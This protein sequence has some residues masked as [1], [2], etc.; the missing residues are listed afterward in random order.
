[1]GA[2]SSSEQTTVPIEQ[3]EAETLAASTGALST[4][5]KCFSNLAD[6]HSGAIPYDSLQ[7]CFRL[8]YE[9]PVCE[10]L[11]IPVSF[12]GVLDHVGC[13]IAE[14]FFVTEK[15]GVSW[16][17]FVRGYNR[18][19]ARKTL[20]MSVTSLLRVFSVALKKAGLPCNLEF[21]TGDDD[22]KISGWLMPVDVL[23]LLW[24]CWA[25]S[26][27][28]RTREFPREKGK[29]CL[30]DV[31]HIVLSA[32]ESCAEAESGLNVWDCELSGL[33]VQLPVG[34]FLTW[35]LKTVSTLPGCFAEFVYAVLKHSASQE[36]GLECSTSSAAVT[37]STMA[38]SSNLLTPGIAWAV[39]L[40][41]TGPLSEE[42]SR[43][44]FPSDANGI[45]NDLLYRSHL[46]GRGLNR[47]WSNVQGYQGPLLVLISATSEDGSA[48]KRNWIV[49]VLTHQGFE[50][51]D[52]FYG[53]SGSLYA[54]S[55]VFHVYPPT[56]KERNFVYSHLH[57]TGK[58]YEVK[59]KPVGIGFGGT[60]GN[61]R[62]YVDEDFSKVT[63][64]HH[65]A[66]K[67][68]QSGS[69]F[70]D[71]GFLPVEALIT[72][73]EIWGLG[74]RGAKDVQDS[75]KNREQ[76]FTEQRRKVDL[77]TFANWEDSPEKMMMDMVSNPN[78]VRREDR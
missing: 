10:G 6:P 45:N 70:P 14:L 46:H 71:Q 21:E 36:A 50:N 17:E 62:I 1:M 38:C 3:R 63:I 18:C 67:T 4:L 54:I 47:F 35:V 42:I 58:V 68:Y 5:Q 60:L 27:Y 11:A 75:Y 12:P 13:C 48:N 26:W 49:G 16:I 31:K 61:E 53:S 77:K 76:L 64:R 56:G 2:S 57:P 78:A 30:P 33:E 25:M 41:L 74:G 40:T 34:K 7:Q 72:E 55:P 44:C 39:S 69:L 37:S 32:I 9:N 28:S 23:M 20:S 43:A 22:C 65:A 73:V 24:M 59:P 8:S 66:D 29:L 15:G 19:C 52:L 51:R